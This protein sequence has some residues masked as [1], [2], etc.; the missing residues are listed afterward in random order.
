ML[1]VG[2]NYFTRLPSAP[3]Y[4]LLEFG[5]AG[6]RSLATMLRF[7]DTLARRMKINTRVR[8]YGF[9][10]FEG[11]PAA[12]D[13]DD[14]AP[15]IKGDFQVGLTHAQRRVSRYTDVTLVPGLFA[16][17]LPSHTETL[18]REP[19]V[20]VSLDCDFYSS[21]IDVLDT[22]IP[23]APHGC[24]FYF[25]DINLNFWST[26]TGQMRAITETNDGRYGDHIELVEFPLHIETGEARHWRQ[27]WR[28][29]NVE[30]ATEM[31]TGDERGP[32]LTLIEPRFAH[33]SIVK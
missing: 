26:K 20:F 9:D 27:V 30:K 31:N 29:V 17:T 33:D 11:M 1:M 10:T 22:I 3:A 21:T 5:V 6:G 23:L 32:D 12:R 15:W 16:D 18:Q 28:L 19:P 25:D 8:A 14:S 24:L 7:R 13:S 2:R 4:S